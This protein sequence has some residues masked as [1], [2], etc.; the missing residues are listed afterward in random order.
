MQTNT[1]KPDYRGKRA[2]ML[3]R[4]S[5]PGQEEKYG[6]PSQEKEIREKLLE[7]LGL[8]LDKEKHVVRDTY[9]GL[10]FRERPALDRILAMAKRGEFDLL[11]M[12]VLDRL[13]RKGIP[14]EIYRMQLRELGVRILTTDPNDHADD[15][16]LVGEMV[17]MLKG[18]QA[19]EELNNI[20]RRTIHGRRAKAEGLQKDGTKGEKKIVGN[21]HRIYGYKYICDEKGKRAGIEL[22]LAVVL[23]EEDGT[24]WTEVKVVIFVFESAANGM[25]LMQIAKILNEKGIPSPYA[26]KQIKRRKV[27]GP[28]VWIPSVISKMLKQSAYY[29]EYRHF[30]T[31]RLFGEKNPGRKDTPRRKT[32]EEEQVI[33]PVP[34]IV[35]RELTETAQMKVRQNQKVAKRNNPNPQDTLLRAGLCICGHCKGNMRVHRYYSRNSNRPTQHGNL[36]YYIDYV[37]RR[38]RDAIGR[39]GGCCI[40][41]HLVDTAAW[42]YAVTIIHNPSLVDARVQE[43]RS[44]DPTEDRRKQLTKTLKNIQ[45]QQKTLR[46]NLA[47]LAKEEILDAGTKKALMGELN[48]L[49]KEEEDCQRELAKDVDFHEKWKRV[50][51]KLDEIHRV[52]ADMH[53]KLDDKDYTP[54][55]ETKRELLEFFGITAIVFK[56]GQEPRLEIQSNPCDIISL[57]S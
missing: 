18:Y 33:I 40:P 9:T 7:P 49:A 13:G 17:R 12:D 48:Q 30:R 10:E 39:C 20:R 19:E 38:N 29:G 54:S 22:N 1:N 32:T 37:C 15:D 31:V 6:L 16:S 24:E 21:G 51:A 46:A 23:V 11:V 47:K 5:T 3:L 45:Q 2:L 27:V 26:A 36:D 14:R 56:K 35:T 52:C 55:Y 41:V 34:A 8:Q 42:D 53:E 4:V 25:S 44:D 28:P 43:L 57:L 50:Q